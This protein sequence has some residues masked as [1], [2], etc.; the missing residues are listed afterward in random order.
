[1]I[2]Y[3]MRRNKFSMLLTQSSWYKVF[4]GYYKHA[5]IMFMFPLTCTAFVITWD[6]YNMYPKY[7]EIQ[8]WAN[9]VDPNQTPCITHIALW[10][11]VIR[12]SK[13]FVRSLDVL[14]EV[15]VY[16]FFFFFTWVLRPF[17]EYFTYIEPIVHQRGPN[18][19]NLG[20]N[21]WLPLSRTWLSHM[22]PE[23]G[24]NHSGEKPNGL[25]VNSSIQ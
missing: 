12:D 9:S 8:T 22:W 14:Y 11:P 15:K 4:P 24:S 2:K 5:L 1:M 20:K 16:D 13:G 25:G 19:E 7:S 17:Q 18:S 21:I 10:R 3:N 23:R 6:R